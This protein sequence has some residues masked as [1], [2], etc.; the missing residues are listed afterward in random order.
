MANRTKQ[1]AAGSKRATV[2]EDIDL[3]FSLSQQS[4]EADGLQEKAYVQHIVL[5]TEYTGSER[6]LTV[7]LPGTD[8]AKP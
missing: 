1:R 3:D 8:F 7:N 4:S 2:T 5:S 6:V